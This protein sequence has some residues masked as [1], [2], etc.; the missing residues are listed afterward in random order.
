MKYKK[1]YGIYMYFKKMI[2][3]KCYLSPIDLNDAE[4][5]T[6]WLNDIDVA[7]YLT[8]YPMMI[9][10]HGEKE[11]LISLSKNHNYGIINLE[12]DELIGNC[13]LMDIDNL[14]RTAEVGIFIGK[15]EYQNRGYGREALTLLIDFGF[16]T[17]NLKNIMLKV[18]SYNDR[19]IK[20][21]ENI[22][23][24]IIGRRRNAIERF[25]NTYDIIFMDILNNE[26]NR[27]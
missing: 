11:A 24:K 16:N 5:Y 10:L 2:G 21:Y 6:E 14:N 23:F 12:N 22:G 7:Q 9:S 8:I 13:G 4:K 18:F 19:A 27:D 1:E 20:C 17:L 15:K 3:T 26:V 25:Q